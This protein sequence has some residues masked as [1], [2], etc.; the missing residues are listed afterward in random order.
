MSAKRRRK[1]AKRQ[2]KPANA[3]ESRKLPVVHCWGAIRS[4]NSTQAP[5]YW[6]ETTASPRISTNL[7]NKKHPN[8]SM[9]FEGQGIYF[10]LCSFLF[11]QLCS[12]V[13]RCLF[14]WA[15]CP[16]T[17]TPVGASKLPGDGKESW[18]LQEEGCLLLPV[19][20]H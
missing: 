15:S 19:R 16:S 10:V 6:T 18:G 17:Q 11:N 7:G 1:P 5:D 3:R 2:Q 8:H 9:S 20:W 13:F 4:V 14:A 12:A